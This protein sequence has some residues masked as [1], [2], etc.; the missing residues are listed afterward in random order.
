MLSYNSLTQ[1]APSELGQEEFG[2]CKLGSPSTNSPPMPSLGMIYLFFVLFICSSIA[3]F[4]DTGLLCMIRQTWQEWH[5]LAVKMGVFM[6]C[7]LDL[8]HQ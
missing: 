2:V 8:S 6:V 7:I 3:V 1:H 4:P 5:L